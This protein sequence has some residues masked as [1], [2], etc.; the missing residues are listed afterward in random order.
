MKNRLFLFVLLVLNLT[1]K[2]YGMQW[3]TGLISDDTIMLCFGIYISQ[4]DRV[5][6]DV[7]LTFLS[8]ILGRYKINKKSGENNVITHCWIRKLLAG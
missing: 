3:I 8:L 4:S 2:P 6:F 7:H 1:I 5:I